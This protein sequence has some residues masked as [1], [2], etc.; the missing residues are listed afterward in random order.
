VQGDLETEVERAHAAERRGE[1][2]RRREQQHVQ[3]ATAALDDLRREFERSQAAAVRSEGVLREEHTSAL[4]RALRAQESEWRARL[5]EQGEELRRESHALTTA[6]EQSRAEMQR[7]RSEFDRQLGLVV[8]ESRGQQQQLVSGAAREKAALAEQVRVLQQQQ[9]VGGH[10]GAQEKAQEQA[11]HA[12]TVA[13]LRDAADT[14]ARRQAQ[15]LEALQSL[16]VEHRAVLQRLAGTEETYSQLHAQ[17]LQQQRALASAE[18]GA[19][20]LDSHTSMQLEELQAR[21]GA[22]ATR[23]TTLEAENK[24]LIQIL[25]TE[26]ELR[27]S[28]IERLKRA[29]PVL[30][31]SDRSNA[32]LKILESQLHSQRDNAAALHKQLAATEAQCSAMQEEASKWKEQHQFLLRQKLVVSSDTKTHL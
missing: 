26:E 18:G 27:V 30:L 28:E 11:V 24:N 21:L 2:K 4:E 22:A 23:I 10:Q 12:R 17:F 5:T 29:A 15:S 6:L 25:K 13:G 1:D 31:D 3:D 16:A 9:L 20:E 7:A 32:H 14:A 19:L 8:Q